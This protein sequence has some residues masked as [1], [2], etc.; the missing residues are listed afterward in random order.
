LITILK[1][2]LKV[3]GIV[4]SMNLF[5]AKKGYNNEAIRGRIFR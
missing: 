4:L 5:P 2:A 3:Q 1:Q